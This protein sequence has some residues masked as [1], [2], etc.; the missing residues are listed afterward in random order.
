MLSPSD[1]EGI[2]GFL[3]LGQ[4]VLRMANQNQRVFPECH[5]LKLLIP[6]RIRDQAQ[7]HDAAQ[8]I[9]IHI[10][11]TAVFDPDV[12]AGVFLQESLDLGR[13]LI[14]ADA[15]NWWMS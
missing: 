10:I 12:D 4:R 14:Q 8:D 13:Q 3:L 9:L 11:G 2:P 6:D 7:V 15:G 1:S 5:C